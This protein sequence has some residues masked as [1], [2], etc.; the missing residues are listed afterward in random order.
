MLVRTDLTGANLTAA[1]LMQAIM[2][3]AIVNGAIFDTASL[4]RADAA[5]MRGDSATSMKGALVK[6]VRVVA[7]GGTDGHA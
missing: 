7:T 1:D 2:Q 3:K 6:R 4:F 5:K